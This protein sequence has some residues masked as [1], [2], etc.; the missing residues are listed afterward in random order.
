MARRT[1]VPLIGTVARDPATCVPFVIDGVV[2]SV[3]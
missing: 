2:L 3:V 1:L